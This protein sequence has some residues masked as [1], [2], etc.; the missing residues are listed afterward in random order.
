MCHE[1]STSDQLE[2]ARTFR[3]L[4]KVYLSRGVLH[5]SVPHDLYLRPVRGQQK[6]AILVK[7]EV[8]VT[9]TD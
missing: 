8:A 4:H 1:N 7:L 3:V 9:E 6:P 5:F 2:G